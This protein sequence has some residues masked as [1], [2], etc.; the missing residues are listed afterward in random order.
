MH[1]GYL[2]T[3]P[4]RSKMSYHTGELVKYTGDVAAASITIGAIMT[5][6]PPIAAAF[7]I[8][9]TAL[10]IYESYLTIKELRKGKHPKKH[11]KNRRDDT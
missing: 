9:W 2:K 8:I 6:L 11:L 5:W 4:W 1:L 3:S 7:T 10:R